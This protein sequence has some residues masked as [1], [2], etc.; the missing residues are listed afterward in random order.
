MGERNA[1]VHVHGRLS[2]LLKEHER[3]KKYSFSYFSHYSGPPVSLTMPVRVEPYTFDTFPP[4]F[5]GLLP[6]GIPLESLLRRSKID[7]TDY[8]SQLLLVG[9]DMV[10][11][12]TVFPAEDGG[13]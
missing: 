9:G 5:D 13:G 6:E 7:K 11:S 2:G 3:G 1:E 12:V 4:F 8:F 10:G